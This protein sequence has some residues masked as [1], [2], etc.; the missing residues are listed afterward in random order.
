VTL[1]A[2]PAAIDANSYVTVAQADA[3][4]AG[5]LGTAAW[6]ALTTAAA[7]ERA[8]RAATT[9]LDRI[10]T[11][12]GTRT[13]EVQAL[14]WP[15]IAPRIDEQFVEAYEMPP[16]LIR[17]TCRLALGLLETGAQAPRAQREAVREKVG[18]IEIE[19]AT[20][21]VSGETF[22]GLARYPLVLSELEGLTMRAGNRVVRT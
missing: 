8:L 5:E 20:G 1:I 18:P 13:T 2:T 6:D 22:V 12:V 9:W 21:S 11:Y 7:K 15:R 17:A 16:R 10:E 19:Y 3:F 14:K 4:F